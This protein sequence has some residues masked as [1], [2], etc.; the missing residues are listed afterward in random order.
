MKMLLIINFLCG[1]IHGRRSELD[2]YVCEMD[3]ITVIAACV[4]T[5]SIPGDATGALKAQSN[6]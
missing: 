1:S 5:S 3:R 2:E 6:I 4:E